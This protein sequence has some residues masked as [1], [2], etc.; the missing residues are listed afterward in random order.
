METISV[1]SLFLIS[2]G[3]LIHII[4]CVINMIQKSAN[5]S[6]PDLMFG[7]LGSQLGTFGSSLE[8]IC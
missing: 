2:I 5:N 8:G 3:Y 6:V 4:S 7:V 1:N